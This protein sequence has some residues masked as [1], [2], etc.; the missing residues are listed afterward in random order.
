MNFPDDDCT[1]VVSPSP[2]SQAENPPLVSCLWQHVQC[3]RLCPTYLEGFS[4]ICNLRTHDA[5]VTGTHLIVVATLEFFSSICNLKG[6]T[7]WDPLVADLKRVVSWV[8]FYGRDNSCTAWDPLYIFWNIL[9]LLCQIWTP[10]VWKWWE[11]KWLQFLYIF[12]VPFVFQTPTACWLWFIFSMK[13]LSTVTSHYWISWPCFFFCG[14]FGSAFSIGTI[15]Q[16]LEMNQCEHGALV[17]W[18]Y[19]WDSWRA[20]R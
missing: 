20:L 9:T 8:M 17:E 14:L 10:G 2:N 7:Y 12:L 13:G 5:M 4:S 3:S 18:G 16:W 11:F 15:Q 19:S 6:R 1:E